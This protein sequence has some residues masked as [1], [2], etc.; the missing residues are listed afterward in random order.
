MFTQKN[1]G[2]QNCEL[3][4]SPFRNEHDVE[5]SIGVVGFRRD[6]DSTSN[7]TPIGDNHIVK[8]Q[9]ESVGVIR[10]YLRGVPTQL[11][12]RGRGAAQ[13]G[14]WPPRPLHFRR[15]FFVNHAAESA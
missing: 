9:L 12:K 5:Q 10:R 7:V 6:W 11:G 4:R 14:Q 8:I 2:R 15:K 3:G 1:L 13:V